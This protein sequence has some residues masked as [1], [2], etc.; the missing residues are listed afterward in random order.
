M[1]KIATNIFVAFA[2]L[3]ASSATFA[4]ER[5]EPA[6]HTEELALDSLMAKLASADTL[7]GKSEP[8]SLLMLGPFGDSRFSDPGWEKRYIDFIQRDSDRQ[9]GSNQFRTIRRQVQIH[10]MF[11]M[12]TRRAAQIKFHTSPEQGCQGKIVVST[13]HFKKNSCNGDYYA[14][15]KYYVPNYVWVNSYNSDATSGTPGTVVVTAGWVDKG[16]QW[17]SEMER[18]DR[19][20]K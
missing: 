2:F 6:C 18:Q 15:E 11:N 8:G 4:D 9:P 16:G 7:T 5:T 10:F 13:V 19:N 14:T 17:I 20:C 12:T 3:L 1:N